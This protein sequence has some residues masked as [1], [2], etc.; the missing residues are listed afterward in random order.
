MAGG[1]SAGEAI[2]V[3]SGSIHCTKINLDAEEV[4]VEIKIKPSKNLPWISIIS[5]ATVECGAMPGLRYLC[6]SLESSNGRSRPDPNLTIPPPPDQL[7]Q[8][9]YLDYTIEHSA[10]FRTEKERLLELTIAG[11]DRGTG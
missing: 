1:M 7:P 2:R 10:P 5:Y 6:N 11:L 3:S 9:S 8:M 4:A